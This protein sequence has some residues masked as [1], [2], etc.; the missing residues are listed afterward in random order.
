MI[1]LKA[2]FG[3]LYTLVNLISCATIGLYLLIYNVCVLIVGSFSEISC[4]AKI[5]HQSFAIENLCF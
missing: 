4:S 5:N 1:P 3:T 2:S